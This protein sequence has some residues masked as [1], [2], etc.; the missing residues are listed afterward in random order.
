MKDCKKKLSI[1]ILILLMIQIFPYQAFAIEG[2]SPYPSFQGMD[3][4]GSLYQTIRFNDIGGH[5]AQ[6]AIQEVAAL[7]LMKGVGKQKFQPNRPISYMEAIITLVK[8]LDLQEEAQRLGE[9]QA[10]DNVRDIVILSTTDNWNRGYLQ[11]AIQNNIIS[12]EEVNKIT[13]LTVRQIEA[14]E[15]T[16]LDMMRAYERRDLTQA[17]LTTIQNQLRDKLETR[18]AWDRPAPRQ[19]VAAWLARTMGL[20]G[21]YGSDMKMVNKFTDIGQIQVDKV[22]LVEAVL[23]ENIMSGVSATRFNPKGSLTRGQMAQILSK[24]HDDLLESHELEK[25]EGEIIKIEDL[26]HESKGKRVFTIENDD[27]SKILLV[28][29]ASE[30]DFPLRKGGRIGLSNLLSKGDWLRYYINNKGEVVYG[31]VDTRQ[32]L[33]L[34]GFVENIDIENRELIV[35]DFQDKRHILKVQPTALVQINGKDYKLEELLYGMEIKANII[36]DKIN[37]IEGYLDED[38]DRH[39][40]IHPGSRTKVGDILFLDAN[41]VEISRDGKRE[42]YKI[43]PATR[44]LRNERPANLFEMKTGDRVILFFNDIYSPDIA[45]IRVEDHERHI[46][47]VY[48]GQIEQVDQRKREI[49]LK[50]IS[51]YQQGRWV[52]YPREQVKLKAEGD[53]LYEGPQK[54]TLRDLT[55]RRDMEV[56]AAVEGSFGV[57]RIA[58]ALIKGGSTVLYES[59]I[60]E[61]QYGSSRMIVDNVNFN[62]H[63]GTIV[64]KNNRLVD[65]L[66][67]GKNQTINMVADLARGARN[68]AFVAIEDTGILDERIDSTRL[69]IYRGTVEDIHDYGVNLGR[70]GYRLDYLRL[71][72]NQWKEISGRRKL[73]LTEDA[74]ILDSDL[75]KEIE[76]SYFIDTRFID[77]QD[78]EDEELRRRIEERFY[79]GKGA[80]FI[81][82]ETHVDGDVYEEVLALNLTPADIHEGGRLHIEHSAIGEVAEVNID[83]ESIT[84]TNLKHWN[85]LNKRWE[86]V[87]TQETISTD[88]AVILVNDKPIGKDELYNI[89]RRA[90]VYAVKSKDSSTG[91]DA[92]VIIVEQ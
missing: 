20:E 19:Q 52:R 46:E 22:P 43:T 74:L 3:K 21:V 62:F 7:G 5:W 72:D 76:P 65:S 35:S 1:F 73:T 39:G 31:A 83:N 38:P 44:L 67:L 63:P 91:D 47:G 28:T 55:T 90:K 16:V 66:N 37:K 85:T 8:A 24:I 79:F 86:N 69:V 26:T 2:L 56:Y 34:R 50:N 75:G 41:T 84:L 64:I 25:F 54:I 11:A 17:E 80:Y 78:I 49:I 68:A 48:R 9:G 10:T 53:L 30:K 18:T 13:D 32:V 82:K 88:K 81:V 6:G 89:R 57:P 71:E 59:R 15:D 77:P 27:N 87:R 4:G 92:Y 60:S 14:L 12:P 33:S 23:Q 36:N 61:I 45:T 51:N 42:K 40:Y 58:K 29:Q 70:L